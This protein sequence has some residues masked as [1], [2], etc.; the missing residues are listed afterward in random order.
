MA[1][2][3]HVDRLRVPLQLEEHVPVGGE[4]FG[5]L[6]AEFGRL[7]QM[8][9]RFVELPEL[10]LD[11]TQHEKG[12]DIGRRAVQHRAAD[13]GRPGEIPRLGEGMRPLHRFG[14]DF[15][16]VLHRHGMLKEGWVRR[17][18]SAAKVPCSAWELVNEFDAQPLSVVG[19][20]HL[21]RHGRTDAVRPAG[22]EPLCGI[23]VGR[24]GSHR[25]VGGA[26]LVHEFGAERACR[27]C[28]MAAGSP[29]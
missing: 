10:A 16:G 8:P 17:Q 24:A 19:L 13:V 29:R 21:E 23:A 20:P 15:G 4:D 9:G 11:R 22:Q 27:R 5:G 2:L 14:G 25:R 12:V 28:S 3:E 7:S 6:R 1:R 26:L 18:H